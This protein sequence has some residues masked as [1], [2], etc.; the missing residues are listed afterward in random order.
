[1]ELDNAVKIRN[2]V[3]KH[4]KNKK[5][6]QQLNILFIQLALIVIGIIIGAFSQRK[7]SSTLQS[8]ISYLVKITVEGSQNSGFVKVLFNCLAPYAGLLLFYL[9][10]AYSAIGIPFIWGGGV[11]FGVCIGTVSS[12]LYA[13]LGTKGILFNL[14]IMLP[15]VISVTFATV[16][17]VV[18]A[19][20]T[21]ANMFVYTFR[22]SRNDIR[23]FNSIMSS[24]AVKTLITVA[25]ASL[26]QA[27]MLKMMGGI[28][29]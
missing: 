12:Y 19:I 17:L 3:L 23:Q 22:N 6:K 7:N 4:Q 11:F 26:Y 20:Q 18:G 16:N 27:L 29:V 24:E 8:Y 2:I 13:S 28:F 5:T 10:F 25:V 15:A 21:S 1:M 14:I 9:V